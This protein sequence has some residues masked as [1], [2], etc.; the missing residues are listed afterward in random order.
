MS[1]I[2]SNRVRKAMQAVYD[3]AFHACAFS[4]EKS[5]GRHLLVVQML[6]RVC[7]RFRPVLERVIEACISSFHGYSRFLSH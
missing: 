1:G 2:I 7:R 6:L 3:V 5:R 4:N